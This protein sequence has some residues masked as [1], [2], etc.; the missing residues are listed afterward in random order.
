MLSLKSGPLIFIEVSFNK[1]ILALGFQ[2]YQFPVDYSV[3]G[4]SGGED[5]A[6]SLEYYLF[7]R[8]SLFLPMIHLAVLI[9][10]QWKQEESNGRE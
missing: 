5:A 10:K 6:A 8:S 9:W 1:V 4:E 2:P 3:L 7:P